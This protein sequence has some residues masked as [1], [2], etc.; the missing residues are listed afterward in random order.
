ME[1]EFETMSNIALNNTARPIAVNSFALYLMSLAVMIGLYALYVKLLVPVIEGPSNVVQYLP[2]TPNVDLPRSTFDKSSFTQLLPPDAWENGE[3]KTLVTPQGTILFREFERIEG[4]YLEVLPFTLLTATTT[5][6]DPG[7]SNETPSPPTI[8]RCLKGARLKFDNPK[9]DPLG[10]KSK[11]ESAWL[12]GVVDI[13]R[14]AS[15]PVN[16]D[17]IAITTSNVQIDKDRIFTIS[18]VRFA[19]G[20]NRG[21]GRNLSIDFAHEADA[22]QLIDGFA[23]VKGI[24]R[25]ELAFLDSLRLQKRPTSVPENSPSRET[26]ADAS[27]QPVNIACQG[28]FVFDFEQRTAQFRDRVVVDVENESRDQ[29][30]CEIL[31]VQFDIQESPESVADA[32]LT[33]PTPQIGDWELSRLIAE[34]APAEIFSA[35]RG[36][37]ATGD[38]LSYDLVNGKILAE[39]TS[40]RNP[41]V[42]IISPD[43]RITAHRISYALQDNGGLGPIKADGP[44]S[45]LRVAT[46]TTQEFFVEW[47]NLLN[48]QPDGLQHLIT[49]DGGCKIRLD[50]STQINAQQLQVWLNEVLVEQTA[51]DGSIKMVPQYQP[52]RLVA[53]QDVEIVSQRL[54]GMTNKLT[55]T[56]QLCDAPLQ[57][58]AHL[59][60]EKL[61]QLAYAALTKVRRPSFAQ[62]SEV[63]DGQTL[64]RDPAIVPSGF[65]QEISAASEPLTKKFAFHGDEVNLKLIHDGELSEVQDL[66]ATGNVSI[67]EVA[68]AFAET[69]TPPLTLTG[70]FLR[71]VPQDGEQVRLLVSGT[72]NQP[73][74]VSANRL[75]LEGQQVHLDQAANKLWVDGAG[76][77][78]LENLPNARSKPTSSAAAKDSSKTSYEKVRVTWASGMVFDGSKIYFEDAVK[79]EAQGQSGDGNPII[80]RSDS[81]GLSL[82]L[83]QAVNFR[84]LE[85][86]A[87]NSLEVREVILVDQVADSQRIFRLTNTSADRSLT[88]RPPKLPSIISNQTLDGTGITLEQ[89]KFLASQV[90]LDAATGQVKSKGPGVMMLYRRGHTSMLGKTGNNPPQPDTPMGITLVRVNF[91]GSAEANTNDKQLLIRGNVRTL[92]AP[93]NSFEHVLDPDVAQ[94]LPPE[95]V[96]ITCDELKL[97]QWTP[98]NSDEPSQELLATGNA[99]ITSGTFEAT[100]DRVSYNQA[101][102]MLVVE[103]TPR[104]DA[105]LWFRQAPNSKDRDHLVAGKILYRLADQW[106]EVQS[107]KNLNINRQ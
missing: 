2:V 37:K 22:N 1:T 79:M 91:D 74:T 8:L 41:P 30:Q 33:D 24:Q 5:S 105:N 43:L 52:D 32:G 3:C 38:L 77:V 83:N 66:T 29:I 27:E 11:L 4:G 104:S 25:V 92:H 103:G 51:A 80:T 69:D 31:T 44:G 15:S 20:S 61:N 23:S 28:P 9:V 86:D 46:E 67:A 62:G 65:E 98:R 60:P 19:I 34:G 93:V 57:S 88:N 21:S 47:K 100:A 50:Q 85:L 97:A 16:D 101:T 89:Q 13:F 75:R 58:R 94:A 87:E 55:A 59:S 64:R 12:V 90:T 14:P 76:V 102:D 73:A 82:Q 71:C 84:N 70:N 72:P 35:G 45:L 107:V 96:R 81:E 95:S 42:T 49:L 78:Q 26:T 40:A 63:S 68:S 106:T 18:E 36:A 6:T 99:H 53:Q 7:T 48:V 39:R 54:N 17:A 10:G 56:W